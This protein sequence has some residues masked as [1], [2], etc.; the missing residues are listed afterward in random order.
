MYKVT[1]LFH[2]SIENGY[3]LAITIRINT[4]LR[5]AKYIKHYFKAQKACKN[6]IKG[7]SLHFVLAQAF[8]LTRNR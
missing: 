1:Q 3:K 5:K 8:L 7:V 2:F 4:F 6:N